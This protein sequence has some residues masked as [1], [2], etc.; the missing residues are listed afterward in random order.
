M[1]QI[2]GDVRPGQSQAREDT[3]PFLDEQSNLLEAVD[4]AIEV[5]LELPV[6]AEAELLNPAGEKHPVF[7][8]KLE[9]HQATELLVFPQIVW[10]NDKLLLP[11]LMLPHREMDFGQKASLWDDVLVLPQDRLN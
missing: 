7:L 10:L 3:C 11:L 2:E 4:V 1:V 6:E 5:S 9:I 8:A